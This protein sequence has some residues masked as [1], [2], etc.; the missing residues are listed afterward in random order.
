[1]AISSRRPQRPHTTLLFKLTL[2]P[3]LKPSVTR[4]SLFRCH[5]F[6]NLRLAPLPQQVSLLKRHLF[7]GPFKRVFEAVEA[8][9]PV[10]P[11][12]IQYRDEESVFI[13]PEGDRVIVI[14]SINFKD[15]SD[16]IIAKV[17]LQVCSFVLI[18]SRLELLT[19]LRNSSKSARRSRTFHR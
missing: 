13:K 18:Y 6:V 17:F 14:F 4:L 1:M 11:I 8:G 3:H 10:N 5:L 2:M 19:S 7:A 15:S 16:T 12:H 9:K